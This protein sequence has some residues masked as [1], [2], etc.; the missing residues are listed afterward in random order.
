M[1]ADTN[2]ENTGQGQDQGSAGKSR[3]RRTPAKKRSGTRSTAAKRGRPAAASRA[4]ASRSGSQ[5]QGRSAK[6]G[7]SRSSGQSE[8]SSRVASSRRGGRSSR[9]SSGS[10][11]GIASRVL[12]GGRRA[13]VWAAEGASRAIP[14]ASRGIG[15]QRMVQRLADERPYMLGA[16]GLGIGAMIGLMLPGTL[17]SMMRSSG[18]RGRNR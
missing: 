11:A 5:A 4:G 15:D 12:S 17:S 1:T 6:R 8:G 13:A 7:R 10:E 14:L 18:G 3:G 16:I 9:R 2:S